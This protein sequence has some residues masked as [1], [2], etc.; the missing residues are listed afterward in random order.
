MKYCKH[1]GRKLHPQA[2]FCPFCMGI[3]IDKQ[4]Y[5]PRKKK[6]NYLL[7]IFIG[8]AIVTIMIVVL[9]LKGSIR[10]ESHN[11]NEKLKEPAITTS[12]TTS[13]TTIPTMTTTTTERLNTSTTTTTETITIAENTTTTT[14]TTTTEPTHEE[15]TVN[16]NE[17]L[18]YHDYDGIYYP[19]G[20]SEG[21]V[22]G[23][24]G[25][26]KIGG[27]QLCI[28]YID[29]MIL[30][31]PDKHLDISITLFTEYDMVEVRHRRVDVLE[32]QNPIVFDFEDVYGGM[33]IATLLFENGKVHLTTIAY[34]DTKRQTKIIVDE[35]LS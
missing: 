29:Q 34:E 24:Y 28:T 13:T 33:G 32:T 20:L 5:I 35:W 21:D 15:S 6:S 4:T 10:P 26:E 8:L 25:Y 18:D 11:E 9:F 30:D 16:A 22:K 12:V 23:L 27:V 1:C 3:Q 31:V 17:V 2:S 19:D 7:V 14:E